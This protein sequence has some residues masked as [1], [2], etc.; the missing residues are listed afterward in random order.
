MTFM[1]VLAF[2][3][4]LISL[5]EAIPQRDFCQLTALEYQ[6]KDLSIYLAIIPDEVCLSSLVLLVLQTT[7]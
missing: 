2:L 7:K 3:K 6:A 4:R 1:S 5:L